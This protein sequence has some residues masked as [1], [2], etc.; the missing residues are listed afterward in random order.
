[1]RTSGPLLCLG[2]GAAFGA[3]AI[4]G[5]L[6]YGEGA[7][8]GTLLAVRFALAAA[9]FWSLVLAGGHWKDV[10]ALPRRDVALGL[11]LGACGYALQSGCYFLALERIDASLLSLLL[12]TF[13]A[14]VAVAAVALG[15]ERL[16][17]RRIL[18]LGLALTGLVLVV[19]GAGAGRLDGLGAALGLGAACIYSTYILVSEGIS[20]RVRA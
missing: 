9:L 3:M 8:V 13:P 11:A 19:A 14:I 6:A 12:Y 17:A 15:R 5:K 7:T 1:M 18:A 20:R 16:D 4:F 10:R 2:S